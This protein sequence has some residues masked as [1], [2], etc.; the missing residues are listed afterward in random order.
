M[1]IQ[2]KNA[3]NSIKSKNYPKS[4]TL[5]EFEAPT[6]RM[7][8]ELQLLSRFIAASLVPN[9]T[10]TYSV[11]HCLKCYNSQFGM[12]TSLTKL[13]G[14]TTTELF[15]KNPIPCQINHLSDRGG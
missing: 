8:T 11:Q 9:L 14:L 2:D 12:V 13:Q 7:I 4:W 10:T 5:R 6:K 15:I 3:Q 1:G